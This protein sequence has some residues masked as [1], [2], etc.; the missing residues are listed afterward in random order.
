MAT[1]DKEDVYQASILCSLVRFGKVL[2]AQL[3]SAKRTLRAFIAE[4]KVKPH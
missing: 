3:T 1:K 4:S 2:P